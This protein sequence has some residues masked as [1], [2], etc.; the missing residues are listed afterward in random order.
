IMDIAP[1][2]SELQI[3]AELE[4]SMVDQVKTEQ[5]VTIRF[6]ALKTA[7]TLE[8]QGVLNRVG[9]DQ[10]TNPTTGIPYI[11]VNVRL[12]Q[13]AL[14]EIEQHRIQ[15]GVPVELLIVTGEQTLM[16]YLFKPITDRLFSAMR[17][18]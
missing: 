18:H 6:S 4:P 17:E 9:A 10:L 8:V 13:Q 1:N 15:A 5:P 11:P 16:Q 14:E 2:G 7:Q 3:S 12:T